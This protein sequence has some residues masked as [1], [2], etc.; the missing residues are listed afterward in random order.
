MFKGCNSVFQSQSATIWKWRGMKM[1]FVSNCQQWHR[2]GNEPCQAEQAP[3]SNLPTSCWSWR[4][5]SEKQSFSVAAAA[6]NNSTVQLWQLCSC[7]C[8]WLPCALVWLNCF[9]HINPTFALWILQHHTDAVCC[10]LQSAGHKKTMCCN[11]K[12]MWLLLKE[13]Q[14]LLAVNITPVEQIHI[15]TGTNWTS[16][17]GPDSSWVAPR[18]PWRKQ[19]MVWR[20]DL[21]PGWI[22][23]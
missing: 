10:F 14:W 11:Q 15:C 17:T 4:E 5:T 20:T 7:Q 6:H 1:C 8:C 13:R 23:P 22:P 3:P 21:N 9:V 16:A 18:F 19:R 2:I 12:Q